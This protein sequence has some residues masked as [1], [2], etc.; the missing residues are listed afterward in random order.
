MKQYLSIA[1]AVACAALVI[2]LVVIKRGDNAQHDSDTGQIVNFS[3]QLDSANLQIATCV[4]TMVTL[5]NSLDESQSASLTFSNQLVDAQSN[6]VFYTEQITNLNQQ[7]AAVESENQ[8]LGKR[9]ADL[10]SQMTNQIAALTKQINLTEAGLNQANKD[11]SL[12]ENRFR[13]NVAER[14]VLERKFDDPSELQSQL[15]NLKENP[16]GVV[17]PESIYAGLDVEVRSNGTFHVITPN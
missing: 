10:S 1:L 11:Y 7:I 6:I 2:S 14:V 12:L 16:V 17:T 9:V 3:N 13:V 4:G 5:S 15:Q 8:V